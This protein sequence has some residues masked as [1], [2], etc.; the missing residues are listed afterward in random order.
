MIIEIIFILVICLLILMNIRL[1]T[2]AK[3]TKESKNGA[4]LSGFE[5]AKKLSSKFCEEEPHIIKKK[6]RFLDHYNKE[7]N[8]IKLSP[9]VFDGEDMYAATIAVNVALET[10]PE[11]KAIPFGRKINAFLVI[12]S[13]IVILLG[14]FANSA[15]VIHLGMVLFILTFIIEILLIAKLFGDEEDL[16]KLYE[17]IKKENLIKPAEEYEENGVLLALSRMATLPYSF[18]NYFR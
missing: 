8:V 13:Y 16:K 15:L 14:A 18:I 2:V 11:R 17:L 7:R 10:D 1:R 5:I 4:K 3:E 9:E 6:G 12:A